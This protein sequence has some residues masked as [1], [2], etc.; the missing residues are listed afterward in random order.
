MDWHQLKYFQT[1][2]NLCSFTKASVELVL[3]QPALSRSI[4]RLEEEVGVPLFERKSRGV[5]LN[6][7][8][9]IFLKHANRALWEIA[10]AKQ[11]ISNM[12][13]PFHGTLLLGFIQPLGSS[14]VPNLISAFQ[15]QVPGIRFQ[16]T[17]DTTKKIVSQIESAEVDIGFC[18]TQEPIETI[19]S[20]LIMNQ[21]LFLIVHK[22]HRLADRKQVDLCEVASDPFVLYKPETALHDVIEKL[23]LDAGFQPIMS[24]EAFE[25]RTVAGLVG[26][27]FGVALIPFMP[28]LDLEKVSL[29]RVCKPH[30]IIG[31]QMVWRTDGYMSPAVTQFKSFVENSDLSKHI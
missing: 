21:E 25:E 7:Y 8:G 10:E 30:C 6:R 4:S 9:E 1:L 5:A 11:E 28:G 29:I 20:F 23:C 3:S 19:S 22:D 26:A 14:F 13:D 17:Q 31:I 2:A 24:F 27:K 12:V 18:S 15:K 16:L